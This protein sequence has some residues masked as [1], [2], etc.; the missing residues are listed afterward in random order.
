VPLRRAPSLST[1][2]PLGGAL[3]ANECSNHVRAKDDRENPAEK[4]DTGRE[5]EDKQHKCRNSDAKEH[6]TGRVEHWGFLSVAP[7]VYPG[8]PAN[9]RSSG[10]KVT[11]FSGQRG[12]QLLLCSSQR[13]DQSLC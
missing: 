2:A 13:P 1:E 9:L 7:T 3:P 4:T 11:P 10:D 8:G 5:S 6:G 12:E